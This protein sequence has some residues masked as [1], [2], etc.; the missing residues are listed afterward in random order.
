MG[1]LFGALAK[2]RPLRGTPFDPFGYSKE[3]RAERLLLLE[4]ERDLGRILDALTPENQA[5]A[6]E[7]AQLPLRMRGYGHVKEHNVAAARRR[8]A[9]ILGQMFH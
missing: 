5:L 7:F 2:L 3:R 6:L 9:E 1:W 4:Y 8:G